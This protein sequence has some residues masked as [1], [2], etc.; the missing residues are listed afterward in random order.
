MVALQADAARLSFVSIVRYRCQALDDTLVDYRLVV[1]HDGNFTAD[2]ANVI[3]L[4]FAGG[5]AGVLARRDAAVQRAGAVR[6]WRP[7]VV[8][9]NLHLVAVAQPDATVALR[10]QSEFGMELEVPESLHR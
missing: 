9:E 3:G 8:I 4:P 7:A 5:L 2:Q 6:V 1:E 10:G